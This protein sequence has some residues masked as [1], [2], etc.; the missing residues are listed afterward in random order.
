M[1]H[2]ICA[3]AWDVP[4]NP[5][6]CCQ[7]HGHA[8]TE[9][10]YVLGSEGVLIQGGGRFPYKDRSIF[11]YQPGPEHWV[12]N[13]KAGDHICIGVVGCGADELPTGVWPANAEL[14]ARFKEIR[15]VLRDDSPSRSTRLD[16]LC[17]LAVCDLAALLPNA[18]TPGVHQTRDARARRVRDY[19]EGSLNNRFS[20]AEL[21]KRVYVSPDYLRQLFRDEFGESITRYVVRRRIELAS[22]LLRSTDLP[23]KRIAAQA[24]FSSEYYFSRIF[25]KIMGVPPASWRRK[26]KV[27][28]EQR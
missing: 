13:Q 11:V 25:R 4:V 19:I 24:G 3:F 12:E 8:C 18:A 23:I 26:V 16:F 27:Q 17:G 14:D 28:N 6:S 20:L 7:A 9:I 2:I 21:A 1:A 22:D 10:V 15:R 5:G